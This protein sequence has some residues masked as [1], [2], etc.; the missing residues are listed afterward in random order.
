MTRK[1]FAAALVAAAQFCATI[2]IVQ[3]D[4]MQPANAATTCMTA[5]TQYDTAAT[6]TGPTNTYFTPPAGTLAAGSTTVTLS[7]TTPDT[8]GGGAST[9]IAVGD[10]LLLIQMQDGTFTYTNSSSYGSGGS[11]SSAGLYEYVAVSN[12]S[13]TTITIQGTGSGGGLINSYHEAAATSAHGQEVYQIIRVPQYVTTQL[14]SSFRSAYWDGQ[15]GGVAA[16]DVSSTLNLGGASIYANANGFRG[17]GASVASKTASGV[18]NS[19]WVDSAT[20]NGTNPSTNPPGFGFKGEGIF[21]TPDYDYYYSTYTTPSAPSGGTIY[22]ATSGNGYP[23]GDMGMGAPGS[24]GG[25]GTDMDPASNDQNTGGGGGGNGG[26]GGNGGY[27]WTSTYSGT[28]AEYS[29]NSPGLHTAG[30]YAAADSTHNPDIGGRGGASVSTFAPIDIN[31]AYMGGGGGGGSNNNGSGTNGSSGGPG[32]GIVL[33]RIANTSGSAATI[34]AQ[35]ATGNAPSNDGGG[36]GG[37]GGTV[38]ITSPA[39]FSGIT[40]HADGAIGTTANAAA[41]PGPGGAGTQR[42]GPGGGGGGGIVITTSPVTATVDGGA[43]GTTTTSSDTYGAQPG[44]PGI[45]LAGNGA[46]GGAVTSDDVPGISSGA[47]CYSSAGSGSVTMYNG[48]Y[49]STEATYKGANYT[50]SYDGQVSATNNNDFVAVGMPLT[51]TSG[52]TG[53]DSSVVGSPLGG[54]FTYTSLPTI[55]VAHEFYYKDTAKKTYHPLTFT[56][57]APVLPGNWNVKLC[58]SNTGNTAPNCSAVTTNACTS[59]ANQNKWVLVSNSA[60]NL[61]TAEYCYYSGTNGGTA[62]VVTYWTVYTPASA[63]YT[64]FQRYDSVINMTD[65]VSN[66]NATHTELYAG[67]VVLT[68]N[69]TVVSSGCPAGEKPTYAS[70][71]CPGGVLRY[72]VDYRSIVAGAALGTEGAVASL[73]PYTSAG[74]LVLTDDGTTTTSSSTTAANW[75]S[76]SSGMKEALHNNLGT[77]NTLCGDGASH[78]GDSNTGSTFLYYTGI[79]AGG[80]GSSTFPTSPTQATKFAV[81]VGGTSFSLYPPNF[82]GKT[83]QGT[84]TFAVTVK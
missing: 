57:Q 58:Q 7:S 34:Y 28:T 35:G 4:T 49:Y 44:S 17:A 75:A 1:R 6:L 60:T 83:S 52:D 36:G 45:I 53:N 46:G 67:Y 42:H 31:H 65:D 29:Q 24:A 11:I 69:T 15:T 73:F 38:I 40:V 41:T 68:K 62:G 82:S 71:V 55:N 20:M 39:A 13:G 5:A 21:G 43:A 9:P 80:T 72:T 3:L 66:T 10:M 16:I 22:K 64:A 76:F 12:V 32:G 84:I 63:T 23:G 48:P 61:D 25:G 14:T 2:A 37:A 77:N 30:S 50:G 33:M 56:A 81:T 79:P 27:P 59:S 70:G 47:E 78:C 18:L 74:K 54:T 51:N 8:S 19:D 26:A